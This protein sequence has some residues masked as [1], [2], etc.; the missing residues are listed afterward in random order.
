MWQHSGM[1][2]VTLK[3]AQAAKRE[4]QRLACR[5]DKRAAVGITRIG[6]AYGVKVNLSVPPGDADAIPSEVGGVQVRVEVVGEIRP[7]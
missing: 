3:Q 4:V 6:T 1:P 5:I 7:R 2:T